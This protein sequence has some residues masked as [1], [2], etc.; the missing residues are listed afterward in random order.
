MS[1]DD[2]YTAVLVALGPPPDPGWG[3]RP[4]EIE[5]RNQFISFARR[6]GFTAYQE[7]AEHLM[8]A[9]QW[10]FHNGRFAERNKPLRLTPTLDP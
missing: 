1:L 7:S 10:V 4:D 2:F 5:Y 8:K 3:F 9:W 6:S